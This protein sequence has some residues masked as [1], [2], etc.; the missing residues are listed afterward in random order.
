MKS[1]IMRLDHII[2]ADEKGSNLNNFNINIFSGEILGLVSIDDRGKEKMLEIMQ[3]NYPIKFGHVYLN[4]RL[5]NSYRYSDGSRNAVHV[6]SVRSRLVP[7]L[8]VLDNV[9]VLQKGFRKHIVNTKIL[10]MEFKRIIQNFHSAIDINPYA[11]AGSL[12]P[13]AQ[14]IVEMIKA[15]VAGT[16]V[17]VL[18]HTDS[19]LG[20]DEREIFLDFIKSVSSKA[21]GILYIGN[22]LEEVRAVCDRICLMKDGQI[23]KV[24]YKNES[25][26][27]HFFLMFFIQ[28]WGWIKKVESIVGIRRERR[29]R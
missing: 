27:D 22:R 8:S 28:M 2:T 12:S 21:V 4:D 26:P 24:F 18:D 9:F 11:Q 13:C 10:A 23:I 1:E 20:S 19:E 14:Y 16:E 5:V 29:V 7:M 3:R 17:F 25:I 15:M 6:L